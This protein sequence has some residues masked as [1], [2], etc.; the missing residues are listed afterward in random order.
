MGSISPS[1]IRIVVVLPDPLGPRKPKTAP[2]DLQ[3]DG[4]HGCL[5]PESLGQAQSGDREVSVL[6]LGLSGSDQLDAGCHFAATAASG[7]AAASS[8]TDGATA[9]KSTRP[10]SR[11]ST[12]TSLVCRTRPLP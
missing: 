11:A 3:V 10:S 2:G 8:R 1:S 9:P 5:R 6:R 4:I 7:D 12:L